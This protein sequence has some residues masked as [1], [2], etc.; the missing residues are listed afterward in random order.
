MQKNIHPEYHEIQVTCSCGNK[1]KTFSTIS[2]TKLHVEVCNECHP[3][4]TGKQN[5]V[6]VA[7]RVE[8]YNQKYGFDFGTKKKDSDEPVSDSDA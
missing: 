6:D 4:F 5:I 3:F 2:E 1:F 8:K 7:G